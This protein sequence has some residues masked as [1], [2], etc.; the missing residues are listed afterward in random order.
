MGGGSVFL[1]GLA[2]FCAF[3]AVLLFHSEIITCYWLKAEEET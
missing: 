1:L 2:K 3:G